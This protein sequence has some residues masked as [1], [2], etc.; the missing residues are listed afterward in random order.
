MNLGLIIAAPSIIMLVSTVCY[1]QQIRNLSH[2]HITEVSFIMIIKW[3]DI[4]NGGFREG[5]EWLDASP[6]WLKNSNRI[7]HKHIQYMLC[8]PQTA[9]IDKM[10]NGVMYLLKYIY[11]LYIYYYYIY[12]T[13]MCQWS[14]K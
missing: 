8:I 14:C 10:C 2:C 1:S 9:K 6:H 7:K 3:L 11:A 12:V 13:N 4:T 5:E